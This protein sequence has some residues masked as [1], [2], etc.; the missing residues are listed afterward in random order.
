MFDTRKSAETVMTY[1]VGLVLFGFGSAIVVTTI[2]WFTQIKDE[3]KL[4]LCHQATACKKYS[5]VREECA[6]A[7]SFKTCLRIKMGRR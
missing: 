4:A 2:L 5:E 1:L 7:E 6:T 3:T